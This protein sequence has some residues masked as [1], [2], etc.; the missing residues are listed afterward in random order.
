MHCESGFGKQESMWNWIVEYLAHTHAYTAHQYDL[1]QGC[2]VS[3]MQYT[4]T[5]TPKARHLFMFC[6]IPGMLSF[7]WGHGQSNTRSEGTTF[8]S[9]TQQL[10]GTEM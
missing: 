5:H 3:G 2:V 9:T 4:D 1:G 6:G 8:I 10:T 7:K